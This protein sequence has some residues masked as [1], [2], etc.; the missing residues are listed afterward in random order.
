MATEPAMAQMARAYEP[1]EAE[2]AM[3]TLWSYPPLV[4]TGRSLSR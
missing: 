1:H 2:A 4:P 3:Y